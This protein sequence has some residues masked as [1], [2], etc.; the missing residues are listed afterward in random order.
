MTPRGTAYLTLC[1]GERSLLQADSGIQEWA[2]AA[3]AWER[4]GCSYLAA[5]AH[6]HAGQALLVAGADR[7]C[8]SEELKH[9][10]AVA[11]SLGA[12]PLR[13]KI[14]A[15][16]RRARVRL[17]SAPAAPAHEQSASAAQCQLTPRELEVLGLVALGRTNR[18][19]ARALF[20]SEKTAGVHVS[21]ILAKLGVAS[22]S[23]ATSVAHRCGMVGVEG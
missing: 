17:V 2:A 18:E 22:R 4:A 12:E 20:M 5:Y 13:A 21:H 9:A 11:L 15:V 10:H 1:Q 14:E 8:V 7:R 6:W 19:I 23:E 3:E 16:A